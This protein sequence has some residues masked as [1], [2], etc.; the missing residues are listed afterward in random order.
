MMPVAH[1]ASTTTL[2]VRV[3]VAFVL[4]FVLGF[5]RELWGLRRA[6]GPSP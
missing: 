5:E 6:T 1:S 3:F 4:T 2:L